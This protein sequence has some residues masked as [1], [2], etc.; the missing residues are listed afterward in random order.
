[1]GVLGSA[2]PVLKKSKALSSIKMSYGVAY[3]NYALSTSLDS[4]LFWKERMTRAVKDAKS[5]GLNPEDL[6]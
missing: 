1:M 4:R 5:F 6:I 3:Q 2:D